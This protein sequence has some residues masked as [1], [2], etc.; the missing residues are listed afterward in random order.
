MKCFY[1][2]TLKH[3]FFKTRKSD[4]IFLNTLLNAIHQAVIDQFFALKNRKMN[5]I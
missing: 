5:F 2:P 3:F 1:F 4:I